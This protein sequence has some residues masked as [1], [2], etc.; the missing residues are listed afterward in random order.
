MSKYNSR[1]TVVDGIKFD[2]AKE[3]KRYKELALLERA[4]KISGLELQKRYE[5][6]PAQ[7]EEYERFGKRGQKLQNGRRCVEKAVYYIADFAYTDENGNQVVE[8]VKGYKGSTAY[9]VF[10]LKRK[11]ML[12]FHNIKVKEI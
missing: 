3:A 7:Y 12:Y 9:A 5:L 10:A 1:K 2:S 6:I 8:D 4:G 11:S